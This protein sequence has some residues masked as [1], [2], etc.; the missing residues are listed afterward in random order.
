MFMSLKIIFHREK[1]TKGK[2]KENQFGLRHCVCE[3]T[4]ESLFLNF[5]GNLTIF[6]VFK[7]TV[8]LK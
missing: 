1:K 6:T 4:V 8:T 7:L 3:A 5:S 2:G